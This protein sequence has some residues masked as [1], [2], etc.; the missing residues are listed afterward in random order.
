[1]SDGLDLE[2]VLDSKEDLTLAKEAQRCIIHAYCARIRPSTSHRPASSRARWA[3]RFA[4]PLQCSIERHSPLGK[5]AGALHPSSGRRPM[6]EA[7]FTHRGC[8]A[9]LSR[10]FVDCSG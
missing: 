1:M 8:P 10:S 7:G 3:A 5:V 4:T 2:I 6:E 9:S